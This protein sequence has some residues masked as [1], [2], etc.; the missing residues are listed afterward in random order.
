MDFESAVKMSGARFVAL[1][2]DLARLERALSA[3]MLD[4]QTQENGYEEVSPPLLVR[5]EALVG[6]GQLPK[7]AED[8]FRTDELDWETVQSIKNQMVALA[9]KDPAK[10]PN[11][12]QIKHR[13]LQIGLPDN[14]CL[15]YTSPSPRDQRGSRMPSSA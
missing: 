1:R 14:A 8:L 5:D 4:V 13:P 12:Q 6:T 15:L 9:L 10:T 11:I 2:G 3:F 7:F